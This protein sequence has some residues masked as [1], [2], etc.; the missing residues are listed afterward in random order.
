MRRGLTRLT[1]VSL[2]LLIADPQSI[3]AAAIAWPGA[4]AAAWKGLPPPA[5]IGLHPAALKFPPAQDAKSHHHPESHF[6]RVL[7]EASSLWSGLR[8]MAQDWLV[9]DA[10]SSLQAQAAWLMEQTPPVTESAPEL[11]LPM[12]RQVPR[13]QEQA[14]SPLPLP[15]SEDALPDTTYQPIRELTVVMPTPEPLPP[16]LAQ[17]AVPPAPATPVNELSRLVRYPSLRRMP[18][19]LDF[20]LPRLGPMSPAESRGILPRLDGRWFESNGLRMR[21]NYLNPLAMSRASGLGVEYKEAGRRALN[22]SEVLPESYWGIYAIYHA[23]QTVQFEIELE[24][25]GAGVL[26]GLAVNSRQE[27]LNRQGGAGRQLRQEPLN[28][29]VENLAPGEKT[30]IRSSFKI[31]SRWAQDG[32][33]EQTHVRVTGHQPGTRTETVLMDAP[34]AGIIDPPPDI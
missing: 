29:K 18:S 2:S 13:T 25:A 4:P 8:G 34:Q 5:A 10:F 11:K 1:A 22:P 28:F 24:N 7:A 27:V 23:G 31:T 14:P 15:P 3:G 26:S 33:F 16:P 32:S 21:V 20:R 9:D 19:F 17:T 6:S 12:P 30:K